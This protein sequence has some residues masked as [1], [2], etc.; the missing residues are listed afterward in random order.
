M[1]VVVITAGRVGQPILESPSSITVLTREDIRR[2]GM[3]GLANIL[4]N[5]QGVDVMSISASE[6][7]VGI[8][9]FNDLPSSKILS[10][11][12][13]NPI[14]WEF[15]GLTTWGSLPVSLD[16]IERIEIIRGPGSALYGTNAFEGVINI[17]T[18]PEVKSNRTKPSQALR[19]P[20]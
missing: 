14:Y 3:T 17:I 19:L 6:Q 18:D 1:P 2:Y 9:G 4:R 11:F 7:N 5:V 15:Y 12:D 10:L 20:R 8:R 13:S 16:E